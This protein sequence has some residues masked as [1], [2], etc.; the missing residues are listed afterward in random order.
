MQYLPSSFIS[1]FFLDILRTLW[2]I[3]VF[4]QLYKIKK[5]L[6]RKSTEKFDGDYIEAVYTLYRV[7]ILTMLILHF[8]NMGK[9]FIPGYPLPII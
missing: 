9:I 7:A 8:M 4:E 3:Y 6:I 5:K 2:S 1:E